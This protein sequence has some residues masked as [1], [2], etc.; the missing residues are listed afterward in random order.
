MIHSTELPLVYRQRRL[1]ENW[2]FLRSNVLFL[3]VHVVNGK[4]IDQE[5]F[6][7]RNK[8]NYKW[9]VERSINKVE[10]VR[11]VVVFGNAKPEQAQNAVFF[12]SVQ[13]FW[14][15]STKPVLYVHASS[16]EGKTM[17][18]YEP[19]KGLDH[20]WAAQIDTRRQFLRTSGMAKIC[21]SLVE[22]ERKQCIRR[23]L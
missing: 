20:V 6:D 3:G 14:S 17:T 10:E 4:V 16:G 11:A 21:S 8:M 15:N 18:P 2:T 7:A 1:R 12:D 9:V 19:F 23:A 22:T 5:E 13:E